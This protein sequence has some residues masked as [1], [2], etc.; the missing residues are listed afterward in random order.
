M[1]DN[2]N[3][4]HFGGCETICGLILAIRSVLASL[5]QDVSRKYVLLPQNIHYY[6]VT[7]KGKEQIY[8]L[9]QSIHSKIIFCQI[10]NQEKR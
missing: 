2:S 8:T 5:G 4:V 9:A 6:V 10:E 7:V 1:S 3:N